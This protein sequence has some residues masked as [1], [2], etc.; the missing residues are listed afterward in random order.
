MLEENY[1]SS[2]EIVKLLTKGRYEKNSEIEERIV[3]LA[4]VGYFKIVKLDLPIKK[5]SI[6]IENESVHKFLD[7]FMHRDDVISIPYINSDT[8]STVIKRYELE[9]VRITDK[10]H[11]YY[12]KQDIGQYFQIMKDNYQNE[13]VNTSQ[14]YYNDKYKHIRKTPPAIKNLALKG[15]F[16]WKMLDDS[17][18]LVNVPSLEEYILQEKDLEENYFS[19]TE[20]VKLLTKGRHQNTSEIEGRIVQ[21]AEAG[22]FKIVKL[23]LPIKKHLIYIENESVEKFLDKFMHRDDV[24]SKLHINSDILSRV[25]KRYELEE[26]GI[27]DLTHRYYLKQDIEQ[28]FQPRKP[29]Y[30]D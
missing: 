12:L 7:K 19:S 11:R 13:W 1:S 10:I 3:Q 25:I 20:L 5:H 28:Y 4:E 15:Y 29:H 26:V 17:K 6:Y 23:D 30:K 2:T 24:V 8:L 18:F 22:Y 14:I 27:T 9:E 21:L 16:K